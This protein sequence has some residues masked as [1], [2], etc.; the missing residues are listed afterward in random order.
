[1]IKIPLSQIIDRIVQEKGLARADVNELI[2]KKMEQ[3]SGLIT[4]EGAAH[5]IANELGIRL[6]QIGGTS[7][8]KNIL[9]E[10]RNIETVGK[11]TNIFGIREFKTDS[12][13][14][15]VGNFMIGDETGKIRVT[16]WNDL[17]DKMKDLQVGN[18]IKIKS[19]YARENQKG[20]KE[21][22]LND[23]SAII[24]NPPGVEVEV[25]ENEYG[26]RAR[27]KIIE[28]Q[29]GDLNTEIVAHIID[30]Y[31]PVYF[32]VCPQCGKRSRLR[33]DVY[34]CEEH[35][36]VTPDYSYVVNLFLDDG[37][38]RLRAACFRSQADMLL[39]DVLSMKND[40]GLFETQRASLMGQLIKIVGRTTRNSMNNNLEFTVNFITKEI[41]EPKLENKEQEKQ[42]QVEE[43]V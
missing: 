16:A 14:G 13:E 29:E 4:E 37:S 15:R 39:K 11:V 43:L 36:Q 19:A 40:L 21:L 35:G 2:K 42:T 31:A 12:R 18:I 9:P 34:I 1:M 38:G 24:V 26:D 10:M 33:E 6:F 8:I 23:N 41:S 28:L 17:V 32:E 22:H 20:F 7:K 5:I 3:L 25:R 30:I 27:K